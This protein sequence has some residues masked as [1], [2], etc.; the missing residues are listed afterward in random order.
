MGLNKLFE[1]MGFMSRD[2]RTETFIDLRRNTAL[3]ARAYQVYPT[4]DES[5]ELAETVRGNLLACEAMQLLSTKEVEHLLDQL[6]SLIA[7][8]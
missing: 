6:D 8:D 2:A 4:S 3:F 7:A 1:P 5:R